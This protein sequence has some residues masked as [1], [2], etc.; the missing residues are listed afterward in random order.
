MKKVLLIFLIVIFTSGCTDD[1]PVT[2]TELVF[3]TPVTISIYDKKD[4][5]ILDNAFQIC[6]NLEEKYS[7]TLEKSQVYL[8]NNANG[9]RTLVSDEFI[10]LLETAIKYSKMTDGKFDITTHN[11]VEIWNFKS[12]N[13]QIP[14]KQQILEALD[15]TNYKNI[16]IDE[17]CVTLLNGAKID[18]GSIIKG[19]ASDM[20]KE[21]LLD[22]K[23]EK[24]IINVGGNIVTIGSKNKQENWTIGI[25]EPFANENSILMSVEID[26]L[27]VVTSGTYQRKFIIDQELYH[28][29]INPFTG[30]PFKSEIM[31]VSVI[32]K[33]ALTADCLSTSFY[34][35]GMEKSLEIVENIADAEAI[36]ITNN[37][38]IITSSGIGDRVKI[39]YYN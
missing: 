29:I 17:N 25:R 11:L 14:D 26:N 16:V 36:F 34:L 38:E 15:T 20:V 6:K 21:Y 18:L 2:R 9:Q 12:L 35:L 33:S 8:L 32:N 28:H 10:M 22:E 37:N 5:E 1:N 19:Y 3:D 31:S 39:N 7:K 24:A 30:Y 23:I 13:P 27:C 4:K